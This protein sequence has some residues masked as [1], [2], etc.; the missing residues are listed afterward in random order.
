MLK[1]YKTSLIRTSRF[2]TRPTIKNHD[3]RPE[4]TLENILETESSKIKRKEQRKSSVLHISSNTNQSLNNK[5]AGD[6][7]HHQLVR[8]RQAQRFC[9]STAKLFLFQH[10]DDDDDHHHHHHHTNTTTRSIKYDVL[11]SCG[12][13][14]TRRAFIISCSQQQ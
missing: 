9:F 6:V 8:C 1:Y 3:Q 2:N 12:T 7:L 5:D 14:T 11:S 13:C 4:R 10:D